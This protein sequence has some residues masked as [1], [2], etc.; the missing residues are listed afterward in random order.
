M[1]IVGFY[2]MS[3]V[4]V[5]MRFG[6]L[7][8]LILVQIIWGVNFAIAKIGLQDFPP[9]FFV[10]M[11]FAL[12]AV[13]LVAFCGLPPKRD[14]KVL[15]PLSFVLGVMHFTLMFT[16]MQYIDAATASIVVQLQ[17]PFA[18]LLAFFFL[19]EKIGWRRIVGM[20][21]AFAGIVL[22]AG[23][24]R[25]MGQF[26][27]LLSVVGAALAW[28]VANLL[29]KRLGDR[30][31]PI[32]LNGWVSI[33]AAPQLIL[34][35]FMLEDQP[36]QSMMNAHLWGWAALLYQA[37]FVAILTYWIWYKMMQIYP[38]NQVM[39]FT[40]LLPAI[41]ALSG[42]LLLQE[43]ITWQMMVGGAATIL[44]IGIIILRRPTI[45]APA[46]RTGL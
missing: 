27:P 16:G 4:E 25:L 35:S 32:R 17:V 12:V 34:V 30:V 2:A 38:V 22:I 23:E 5:L 24:P 31:D 46:T 15:L 14:L 8:L 44:G 13:M 43:E 42:H 45:A 1:N 26:W 36:W 28:S 19:R 18:S 20:V 33:L 3:D 9:L 11:R 6:H 29:V 7:L 41:G 37:V 21:T 40:L 39:P 10:T